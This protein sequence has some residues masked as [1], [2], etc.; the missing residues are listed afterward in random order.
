[1]EFDYVWEEAYRAALGETDD[2]KLQEHIHAAKAAIDDRL[3]E[4]QMDHGGR[5]E[6]RLAITAA[7]D[8]LNLLRRELGIRF[9]ETG[10]K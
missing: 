9:S 1:M 8:G 4:L 5:P 6:E 3:H 7:L 10:S 2:K